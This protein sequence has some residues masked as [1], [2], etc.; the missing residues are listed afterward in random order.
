M[1]RKGLRAISYQCTRKVEAGY[2]PS[3][4]T[5]PQLFYIVYVCPA[6][7]SGVE[8]TKI[9]QRVKCAAFINAFKKQTQ[10]E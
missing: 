10:H 8:D 4:T 9:F 5:E 7:A 3:Q 1:A 6:W 2:K